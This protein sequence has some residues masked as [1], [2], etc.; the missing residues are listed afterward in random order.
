MD[1]EDA[2]VSASICIFIIGVIIRLLL[3]YWLY[4]IYKIKGIVAKM[5]GDQ[6]ACQGDIMEREMFRYQLYELKYSLSE[7][8]TKFTVSK[9]I[10]DFKKAVYVLMVIST[11]L[12]VVGF[13]YSAYGGFV[14]T[15]EELF[16]LVC[17]AFTII[18]LYVLFTS[19]LDTLFDNKDYLTCTDST[20][21]KRA[22]AYQDLETE[23][24]AVLNQ[25][26][27]V[28][29][30]KVYFM[31]YGFSTL[32]TDFVN[33]LIKRLVSIQEQRAITENSGDVDLLT[34][35]I[36]RSFENSIFTYSEGKVVQV[37]TKKLLPY[38]K[39]YKNKDYIQ[40]KND[41]DIINERYRDWVCMNEEAL[42]K[43]KGI[44]CEAQGH[45]YVKNPMYSL[46]KY[47]T[48]PDIRK[49][50]VKLLTYG[51]LLFFFYLYTLY[52]LKYKDLTFRMFIIA[53]LVASLLF[54]VFYYIM[55]IRNQTYM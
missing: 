11:I 55:V 22:G 46:L 47:D 45:S 27:Q 36:L 18:L 53:G 31:E 43:S 7:D 30:K 13:L 28:N 1:K 39:L 52:H 49:K 51:W 3:I 32:G 48:Y 33:S 12:M 25:Y 38:L 20:C 26:Y 44:V 5:H 19:S 54:V 42:K 29:E 2:K 6:E 17:I 40:M 9:A 34:A 24:D 15:Q 16:Q 41:I 23:L 8:L 35:D 50:L 21:E 37:N 10:F 4:H 14:N